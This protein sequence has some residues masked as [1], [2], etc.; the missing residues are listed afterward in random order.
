MLID[1]RNRIAL[2]REV[3]KLKRHYGRNNEVN[4]SYERMYSLVSKMVK[5][6]GSKI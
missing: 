4:L 2:E 5:K 6:K 1:S 3:R